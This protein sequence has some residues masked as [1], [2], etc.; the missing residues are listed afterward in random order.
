MKNLSWS[1]EAQG[2]TASPSPPLSLLFPPLLPICLLLFLAL[3]LA[4]LLP[5]LFGIPPLPLFR[6]FLLPSPLLRLI[7]WLLRKAPVLNLSGVQKALPFPPPP[8]ALFCCIH[9]KTQRW[10]HFQKNL[11]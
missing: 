6:L 11:L 4:S 1:I 2:R 9:Q 8:A 10:H 7:Q 5:P 3:L